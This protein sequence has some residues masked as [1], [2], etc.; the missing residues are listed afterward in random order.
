M[1]SQSNPYFVEML[2]KL[3]GTLLKIKGCDDNSVECEIKENY[4]LNGRF[5]RNSTLTTKNMRE[6]NEML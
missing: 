4:L 5:Y 6:V 2:M 3:S 1:G